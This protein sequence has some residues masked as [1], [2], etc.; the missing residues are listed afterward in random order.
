MESKQELRRE[1]HPLTIPHSPAIQKPKPK[2]ALK[3][4]SRLAP[5]ANPVP[6]LSKVFIPV[7][8][9]RVIAPTDF[10]LPGDKFHELKQKEIQQKVEQE[11]AEQAKLRTFKA[12]EPSLPEKVQQETN[13]AIYCKSQYKNHRTG[14]V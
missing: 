7:V 10:A 12:H 13:Q 9:H 6:D 5:K 14:A 2:I 4:L 11:K 8:E 1:T 3:P